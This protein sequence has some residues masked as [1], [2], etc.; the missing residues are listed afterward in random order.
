MAARTKTAGA[1]RPP[2]PSAP[3][4]PAGERVGRTPAPAAAAAVTQLAELKPGA[5]GPAAAAAA[6]PLD[7]PLVTP[8]YIRQLCRNGLE[9]A[10]PG[11][12]ALAADEGADPEDRLRAV[13]I[14]ARVGVGYRT[15]TTEGD[16]RPLPGV[17]VLP[18]LQRPDGTLALPS[19][20][21]QLGDGRR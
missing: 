7:R 11:V 16:E 3:S 13:E 1:T 10:L 2:T 6:V 12:A 19:M 4:T 17:I 15:D 5:N 8:S 14:L 21:A 18:A 9:A 20:P